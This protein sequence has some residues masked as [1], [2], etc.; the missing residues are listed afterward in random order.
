MNDV[1]GWVGPLSGG[2]DESVGANGAD[3]RVGAGG[4]FG[5]LLDERF[6]GKAN[7]GGAA[8]EESRG[9]GVAIDGGS[10]RDVVI[11]GDVFRAVPAEEFVLDGVAVGM[12]ADRAF[13]RVPAERHG[14]VGLRPTPFFVF[15]PLF[16][17]VH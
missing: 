10:A 16:E 12:I 9:V 5:H 13:P 14:R 1:A 11:P 6:E 3:N 8:L 4:Y 7:G 17:I 2:V 15:L